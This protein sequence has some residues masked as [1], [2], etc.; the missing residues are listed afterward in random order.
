MDS[1]MICTACQVWGWSMTDGK[2]CGEYSMRGREENLEESLEW[3]TWWKEAIWPM[4]RW[5]DNINRNFKYMDGRCGLCFWLIRGKCAML[6]WTCGAFLDE[7]SD[8]WYLKKKCMLKGVSCIVILYSVMKY[9][10]AMSWSFI[11]RSPIECGVS[12]CDLENLMNE[13]A[14]AHWGLLCQI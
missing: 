4:W 12:E 6:I 7:V 13:E 5:E 14:L 3:K 9:I 11:H 10:S 2:M 8:H 1:L